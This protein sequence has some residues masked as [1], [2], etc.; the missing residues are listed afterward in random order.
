MKPSSLFIKNLLIIIFAFISI[1][2]T[3]SFGHG[4]GQY[5]IVHIADGSREEIGML[6]RRSLHKTIAVASYNTDSSTPTTN[7]ISSCGHSTTSWFVQF[8]LEGS[9]LNQ[10]GS[11][12]IICTPTQEFY[13][14]ST[15]NWV[16][17]YQLQVGDELLCKH[18]T[19]KVSACEYVQERLE[20]YTLEIQ[21][22]HTFFVGYHGV[23]T[24]NMVLPA[25]L[26]LGFSV[27]FG[28]IAGSTAGAFFGPVTIAMG[29]VV[30]ALIGAFVS[31]T[32]NDTVPAYNF[33]IGN[34]EYIDNFIRQRNLLYDAHDSITSATQQNAN[35]VIIDIASP[36]PNGPQKNDEHKTARMPDVNNKQKINHIFKQAWG[37]REFSQKLYDAMDTMVKDAINHLGPDKYGVQWFAKTLEN[38]EQMWAKAQAGEVISAG[39]NTTPRVYCP[40]KGLVVVSIVK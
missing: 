15:Q 13:V 22:T 27:P 4:F 1:N 14:P 18:G 2:H 25:A 10:V 40:V 5:T 16:Q 8:C 30:G 38:G 33:E 36:M 26:G 3:I 20:I 32:M 37:H 9:S 39:I 29:A 11:D 35:D 6:C 24:H 31:T 28:S 17:A 23:L 21:D 7:F 19:K 34:T 12:K